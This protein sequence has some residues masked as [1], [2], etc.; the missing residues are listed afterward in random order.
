MKLAV[1]ILIIL[2]LVPA[3]AGTYQTQL[4]TYGLTLAIELAH[5]E[6]SALAQ[7][8]RILQREYQNSEDEGQRSQDGHFN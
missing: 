8:Y 5:P 3:F 1:P 7:P 4:L 2:A 6:P